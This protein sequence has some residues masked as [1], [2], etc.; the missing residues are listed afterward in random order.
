MLRQTAFSIE[1]MSPGG[2]E[3]ADPGLASL[4]DIGGAVQRSSQVAARPGTP[5]AKR[6]A[7]QQ[8]LARAR[9]LEARIVHEGT[10]AVV[11][12]DDAEFALKPRLRSAAI[13]IDTPS[14]T[15]TAASESRTSGPLASTTDRCAARQVEPAA[16]HRRDRSDA[17]SRTHAAND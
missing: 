10:E 8:L 9:D 3:R 12:L 4:A 16:A 13:E 11:Y 17:L 7:L 2:I 6:R 5:E 14:A 15:A 1:H